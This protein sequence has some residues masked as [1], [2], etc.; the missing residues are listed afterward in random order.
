ML[1]E[2]LRSAAALLKSAINKWGSNTS[3]GTASV[4]KNAA[5][6]MD[7]IEPGDGPAWGTL[8]GLTAHPSDPSRLY[9]VTDKDSP[10]VRILEIHISANSARVVRQIPVIAPG[11]ESLDLEA[12]VVQPDGGFWLASEGGEDNNPPNFLLE[13]DAGGR[14]RRTIDLPESIASRIAK[15]GFEGLALEKTTSSSRLYVAFQEAIAGDR[16]DLTRI[17]A[18][19]VDTGR[20]TFFHYPLE[21]LPSGD[22]TGL[23]ELL[24][25]GNR[26]FAA[27]E[28]DG[29]G[30]RKSVKWITT[31]ELAALVGAPTD[32][33]PPVIAKHVARDLVPVFTGLD[34]KVEKEIEG[35]AVASD[36]QVYVVTDNDNERSTFLL[37]LGKGADIFAFR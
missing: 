31:F 4:G 26:R 22:F 12:I 28:R 18:V 7:E 35:L 37:R 2:W 16:D 6:R 9:A 27:I 13:V 24:H 21:H 3:E 29:K 30:G 5:V 32:A 33:A 1:S 8:S 23:S 11:F 36:G 25:L 17:G 19:D 15:K 34:R 20:W 10:P 14:L